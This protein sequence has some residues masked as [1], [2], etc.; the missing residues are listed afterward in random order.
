[1]KSLFTSSEFME[2][3]FVHLDKIRVQASLVQ[4][5]LPI[6]GKVWVT[7]T[8]KTAGL[9]LKD[10][11]NFTI[12]KKSGQVTGIQW[13]MPKAVKTIFGHYPNLQLAVSL[14]DIKWRSRVGMRIIDKLPVKQT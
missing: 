10:S 12:R 13:W 6:I 11:N 3:P 9:I 5:K 1:M 2:N 14:D 4:V 7:T 8:Q